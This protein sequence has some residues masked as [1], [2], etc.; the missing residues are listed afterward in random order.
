MR[1]LAFVA[2]IAGVAILGPAASGQTATRVLNADR[3]WQTLTL[4]RGCKAVISTYYELEVGRQD[5]P[6]ARWRWSGRCTNGLID[7]QG[8]LIT[9]YTAPADEQGPAIKF[10][11]E[12]TGTA[13]AGLFQGWA[14][15]LT[16]SDDDDYDD[17]TPQGSMQPHDFG[18]ARNPMP[19]YLRNG[20]SY[21]V[22]E[23]DQAQIE[24]DPGKCD[25]AKGVALRNSLR[26]G[27]SVSEGKAAD[28]LAEAMQAAAD[29]GKAQCALSP[30]ETLARFNADV[31]ALT[32][33]YPLKNEGG[34][35]GSGAKAVNQWTA[36]IGTEGLKI[37]ERYRQCLG[38]HN[39]PN[40]AQLK[41]MR[42]TGLA[43]CAR[44][45]TTGR[46]TADYPY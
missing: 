35:A 3:S 46:C 10:R 8:V 34:S 12:K 39:A 37:L 2:V 1:A 25:E 30:D 5:H 7:G 24:P 44:L 11:V 18:D 42:D 15:D 41:A 33:R 28:A 19:S 36:F 14:S 27:P 4:D 43:S 45:S 23:K 29:A 21:Y 13:E 32:T 40:E 9:E 20:C 17:A 6:D 31:K 16:L 26:G 38:P 22:N